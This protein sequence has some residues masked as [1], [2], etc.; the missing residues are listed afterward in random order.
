MA[1]VELYHDICAEI[2]VIE[3]RIHDLEQEYQFWY[4]ACHRG[5]LPLDTCLLRMKEICDQVEI[6]ATMLEQKEKAR[7][8][9]EDRLHDFEGTDQKVAYM[10]DIEG[11][12]LQEIADE[13]GY[14]L[15]WIKKISARTKRKEYTKSILSG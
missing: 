8:E 15:I 6:Y 14:S 12:T 3:F 5:G 9:I 2:D 10:R 11:K 4:K 7:K 13:L 1:A